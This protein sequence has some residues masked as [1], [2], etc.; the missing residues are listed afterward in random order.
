MCILDAAAEKISALHRLKIYN[1]NVTIKKPL[2]LA[3]AL[4]HE[5]VLSVTV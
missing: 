2:A 3:F 4:A 5:V 1:L